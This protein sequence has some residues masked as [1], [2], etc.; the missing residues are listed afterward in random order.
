MIDDKTSFIL[1][2]IVIIGIAVL[3]G[4]Q[5]YKDTQLTK[6][7]LSNGYSEQRRVSDD[8]Y[9]V[10]RGEHGETIVTSAKDLK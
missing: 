6:L 3:I 7:C 4:N 5:F 10:K 2:S 1:F 8:M 9:C